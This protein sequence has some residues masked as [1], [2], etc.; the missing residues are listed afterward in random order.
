MIYLAIYDIVGTVIEKIGITDINQMRHYIS[1]VKIT[2][3]DFLDTREIRTRI[4]PDTKT[5]EIDPGPQ[6]DV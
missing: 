2:Q 6:G 4:N 5:R 1:S 3:D